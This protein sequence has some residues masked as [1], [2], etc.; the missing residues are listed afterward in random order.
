M[1]KI[2]LILALLLINIPNAFANSTDE[3]SL[4]FDNNFTRHQLSVKETSTIHKEN[5]IAINSENIEESIAPIQPQTSDELYQNHSRFFNGIS[6]TAKDVYK[7][8]IENTDTPSCLF[9]DQLTK[10]FDEGPVESVHAW[11]AVQM[12]STTNIPETGDTD[13]RFNVNLVNILIDTKMRGEKDSFHLM[14]DPTH[15]HR[16]FFHT[17][18]QDA[19][20]ESKRIPHHTL[21]IGHSR[22]GVGFEGAQSPY[23]LPLANRSQISRNLANIR[24]TGIRLKGDYSLVDYDFGGYS[25]DTM[26]TEFMPG[27]EFDGWINLK[28]LGKTDGR[29]GKLTTG[30]G[31]V[32]GTRNSVD[33][34][35]GGAY[36]GYTYKKFWTRME[37]ATSDGSNGGGGLT[38]KRQQGWYI[39]LGYHLTK[40][41]EMITR[42]DEFDPDKTKRNN[43]QREYTAGLNYY[44]KG[45][46]FK[47]FLNYVFCQNEAKKDAHRIIL[48]TQIII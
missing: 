40:K 15:S 24:K 11:T 41:L 2:L 26:F 44:L 18:I 32:S 16:G 39:T 20:Y 21:M 46:A 9:K 34:F 28:P 7:L 10:T 23:T 1:K 19:F 37:F 43:N 4:E 5:K 29:Y 38:T 36:V 35:V 27:V 14:L 6:K 12:N 8:Q 42:Y 30:G 13:T 17:F 45:Q 33:Y 31:I 3:I 48:G 25:S 47:V 22:P